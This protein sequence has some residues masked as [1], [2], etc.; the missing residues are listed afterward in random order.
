MTAHWQ[1]EKEAIATI[2]SLKTQLEQARGDAER[3]GREGDLAAASEIT[4]GVIP[5]LERQVEEATAALDELQR[6][7]RFLKEEVDAEDVAEVV[8]RC[9]RRAGQPAARGRGGEAGPD[10]G[11][12]PRPGGGPG[13]GRLGRV[14][15]HPA[16]PGRP[17]QPRPAH[18][19]VPL[20]GA[21]RRGQDRAGPGPGRVPVRRRPGHGPDR[22]E[23]VH[24]APLGGPARRGAPRLRRLRGGRPADRGR[25]P[26]PLR[27][28]AARRARRRP[29]PT[30]ST[31]CSRCWRTAG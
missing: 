3:L 14:Q 20:H 16:Q 4:Y 10:G 1:A 18:R 28:G 25:P 11:R 7:Q 6:D 26:P 29:T 23:R 31:P 9:D 27:G 22:H 2:Q 21:D 17:V 12:P 15:R 13:R 8:S 30:C 19:L 24:G 5:D